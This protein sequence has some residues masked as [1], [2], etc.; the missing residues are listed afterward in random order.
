M[1]DEPPIGRAEAWLALVHG[2]GAVAFVLCESPDPPRTNGPTVF[3]A[4]M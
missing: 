4:T 3:R 2:C 1:G